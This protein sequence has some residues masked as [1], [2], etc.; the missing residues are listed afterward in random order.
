MSVL[1][2]MSSSRKR[3]SKNKGFTKKY[4]LKKLLYF[5]VFTNIEDALIREKRLKHWER[6][7][8]LNLIKKAN[9]SLRDLYGNIIR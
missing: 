1:C 2:K 9:P 6:E 7:W 4:G 5:E 8:K 3:G